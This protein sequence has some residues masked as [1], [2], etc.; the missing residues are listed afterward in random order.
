MASSL[1]SDAELD[2]HLQITLDIIL[3][4]KWPNNLNLKVMMLFSMWNPW[5]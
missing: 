4:E 1:L 2:I 3:Y 5:R